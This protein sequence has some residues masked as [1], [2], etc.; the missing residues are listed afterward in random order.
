MNFVCPICK[1]RL[2]VDGSGTAKCM[3]GHSF[4]KS[5]AGYYNLLLSN[6]GGTHGDNREMVEAR[7][8][9]LDT[10]AYLPL[11]TR[12]AELVFQY[13][14]GNRLL[15][16]GCGEGYYTDIV[17]RYCAERGKPLAVSAFDISKDAVKYAYRRNKKLELA[18]ASAYKM[19]TADADFDVALNMFSPLS[20]EEIRRTL[21]DGGIFIMAI[22]ARRHLYGLKTVLYD[23]PYENEVQS[24]DISG[25]ELIH[26]EELSYTLKLDTAETVR[27][28]FM[29]TPYAYRT[30]REGRERLLSL[31]SLET[32]IAF[33]LFVYKKL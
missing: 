1:G 5:R 13:S 25:F 4:D 31:S 16:I 32:E 17:E 2:S 24:S 20:S 15:D 29:M 30:S 19:P 3:L 8:V 26:S 27:S 6:V 33:V 9:F 18:V 23:T 10:G 22:P 12:V 14:R 7:R 11:A 21:C 28:L